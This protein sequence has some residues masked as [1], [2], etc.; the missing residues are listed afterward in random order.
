[1]AW[2]YITGSYGDDGLGYSGVTNNGTATV[3]LGASVPS[4]S[5][6]VLGVQ[7]LQSVSGDAAVTY[8]ATDNVNSGSYN[9]DVFVSLAT[10]PTLTNQPTR[11]SIMTLIATA[12]GTPTIT[13]TFTMAS[14]GCLG[15]LHCAAYSGIASSS[16]LDTSAGNT[17]NSQNASTGATGSES[18]ANELVVCSVT[19]SGENTTL[20]AA[21]SFTSRGVHQNDG[22][23]WQGILEDEN[24]SGTTDTGT[25]TKGASSP[26]LAVAAVYKLSGAAAAPSII[27]TRTLRG[28]GV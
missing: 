14:G 3:T 22:G 10:Y 24:S 27:L 4:G 2:A 12:T 26:W 25:A 6:I 13:V 21:G 16:Y 19:D 9:E 15:G 18:A 17:G 8:T 28:V 5:L 11:H 20:A 7:T 1:M 23:H